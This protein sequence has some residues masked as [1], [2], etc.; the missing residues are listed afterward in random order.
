MRLLFLIILFGK[1]IILSQAQDTE[2]Q[3][4]NAIDQWQNGKYV[5]ALTTFKIILKS[6]EAD[7]YF[8]RI[9]LQTGE[10]FQ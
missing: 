1:I 2:K 6:A 10:L 5:E 3:Y 9:A 8:T 7:D 4:N